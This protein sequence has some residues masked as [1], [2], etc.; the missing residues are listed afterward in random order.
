MLFRSVC[1]RQFRIPTGSSVRRCAGCRSGLDVTPLS[2][3]HAERHE[4]VTA[5]RPAAGPGPI[6]AATLAALVEAKRDDTPLGL[7]T[8]KL[9]RELD[10]AE[11]VAA[12]RIA[13]GH[14]K[15]LEAC[16]AGAEPPADRLDE[17]RR[18]REAKAASA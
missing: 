1:A 16:L 17:L 4:P 15:S 6:E 10:A 13:E 7:A 5:A 2:P 3:R 8:V 18:R 11:G 12:Q 14:R 9:A